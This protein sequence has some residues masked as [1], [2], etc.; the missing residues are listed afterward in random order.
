MILT[1]G[2]TDSAS[3]YSNFGTSVEMDTILTIFDRFCIKIGCKNCHF[4]AAGP[5]TFPFFLLQ[6]A[7]RS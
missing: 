5:V 7:T 4:D 6:N 3:F 1:L 2:A